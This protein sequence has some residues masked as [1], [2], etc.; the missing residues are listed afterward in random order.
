MQGIEDGLN[1]IVSEMKKG[2]NPNAE[3]TESAVK[4]LVE[5]KLDK[6][7][8]GAKEAS[9]AIGITGDELIGNIAC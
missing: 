9:E 2:K 6:I 5:S 8:G 4:T 1:K 7:I 3:A